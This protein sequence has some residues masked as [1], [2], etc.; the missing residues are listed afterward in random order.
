MLS[1]NFRTALLLLLILNHGLLFA[2][3][4]KLHGSKVLIQ[5]KGLSLTEYRVD[6]PFRKKPARIRILEIDPQYYQFKLINV[7]KELA[8]KKAETNDLGKTAKQ[9]AAQYQLT[10][11]INASMFRQDHKSSAAYMQNGNHINS[12]KWTKDNIVLAFDPVD[13]KDRPIRMLDKQCDNLSMY[14]K[15]YRVLIQNIRM[16]SCKGK[17]V[18][19]D[20][21]KR[22]SISAVGESRDNKILFIHSRSPF[23]VHDFVT[24]L[25]KLP[26]K[27]SR[28]MYVEGGPEA[29][30]YVNTG[31]QEFEYV[32]SYETGFME[33]SNNHRAWEL[34]N[35]IG[36]LPR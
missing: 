22:W 33:N 7:S 19:S 9:W 34:P 24:I 14:K 2:S 25:S 35:V 12:S 15:R 30:L 26:I 21:N 8:N 1:K 28:A 29:T 18:W 10:A 20:Q 17:N 13:I 31:K 4:F 16:Y 23:K 32:G 5:S 36:I 11:A 27:L 6:N 3:D